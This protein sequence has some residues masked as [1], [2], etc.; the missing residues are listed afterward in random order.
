VQGGEA[1]LGQVR[2]DPL[3]LHPCADPDAPAGG[4][5]LDVLEL[6]NVHEERVLEGAEGRRVVPGRLGS[7]PESVLTRVP[8]R[9]GDVVGGARQRDAGRAQVRRQIEDL[10]NGVPVGIGRGEDAAG[11]PRGQ[12]C[13]GIRGDHLGV[14]FDEH[15]VQ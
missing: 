10:P 14:P 2:D 8:D 5:D 1:E 6:A 12:V 15:A 3:P 4:V 9:G 13:E 7:D 11:H